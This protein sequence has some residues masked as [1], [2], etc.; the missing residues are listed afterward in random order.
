MGIF[1]WFKKGKETAEPKKM[2]IPVNKILFIFHYKE[3]PDMQA[4]KIIEALS[5]TFK[6]VHLVPDNPDAMIFQ[7]PEVKVHLKDAVLPAQCIIAPVKDTKPVPEE[8]F[9]QCW[10]WEDV[11]QALD[12]CKHQVI[13]SDFLSFTLPYSQRIEVMMPFLKVLLEC[14]PP[15][16]V[17]SDSPQK[18][19][20]PESLLDGWDT[21]NTAAL[22][23]LVNVRMFKVENS[24]QTIMDTMGMN[25][26]GLPD[27]QI[28]FSEIDPNLVANYLLTYAHYL[29]EKGD[30]I[31]SGNTVE[32]L[33]PGKTWTVI[34][35]ISALDDY[36][37][38]LNIQTK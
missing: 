18:L 35:Q 9:Q 19:F 27:F 12:G 24:D 1:D 29:L 15:D 36:K 2:E 16:V 33:T 10:H 21:L 11:K 37:V 30:V 31:E 20:A 38:V 8:A 3:A 13:V 5:K 26:L 7:F 14:Y 4:S 23:S 6:Q 22:Y 25:A 32:A 28:V 17:Y 34:Q